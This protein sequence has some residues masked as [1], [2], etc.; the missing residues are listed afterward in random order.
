MHVFIYL[1]TYLH[2]VPWQVKRHGPHEK[3]DKMARDV[4][5]CVCVLVSPRVGRQKASLPPV[6][7]PLPPIS[8]PH[9]ISLPLSP[10]IN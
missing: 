4:A 7:P 3:G 1:Y 5:Q 6:P 10:S 2:I 9:P 8:S